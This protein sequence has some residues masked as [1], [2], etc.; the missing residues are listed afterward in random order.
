MSSWESEKQQNYSVITFQTKDSVNFSFMLIGYP[1]VF[2][3]TINANITEFKIEKFSQNLRQ[4]IL[5]SE[6]FFNILCLLAG[7]K[8]TELRNRLRKKRN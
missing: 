5:A 6:S 4:H 8:L 3:S 2:I 1:H 7:L